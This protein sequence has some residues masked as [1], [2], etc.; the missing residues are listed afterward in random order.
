MTNPGNVLQRN[1]N[2]RLYE[3][4][5]VRC[6]KCDRILTSSESR[7]RRMCALCE[8]PEFYNVL[9]YK[10]GQKRWKI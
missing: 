7:I 2:C 1:G 9:N 10:R 6:G 4:D 8:R 3:K 5:T